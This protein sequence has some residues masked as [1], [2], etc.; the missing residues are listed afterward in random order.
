M[1]GKVR[2][3]CKRFTAVG[4]VKARSVALTFTSMPATSG[5]SVRI[6]TVAPWSPACREAMHRVPYECR[7]RACAI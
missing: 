1:G 6:S 5:L 3:L 7:F 2:C 4:A